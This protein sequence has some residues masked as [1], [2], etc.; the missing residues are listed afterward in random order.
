MMFAFLLLGVSCTDLD[1]F[2]ESQL[3]ADQ[4]FADPGNIELI[5]AKVYASLAVSG[6]SGPSGD[7]DLR[8][9]DEGRGQYL[10]VWWKLQELPTDEAVIAW[11]DG[12]IQDLNQQ[13]WTSEEDFTEFAYQQVF[14]FISNAN[15]F[16][17]AAADVSSADVPEIN[18]FIAEARF[19]RALGYWHGIDLFGNIPFATENDATGNVLPQ[20][21]SRAEIFEFIE[22]ELIE[23]ENELLPAGSA[24]YGRA[25]RGAAWMLQAKLYLNAEV[26]TGTDRYDDC[27]VAVNKIIN[28]GSYALSPSYTLN[29]LA[30]NHTSPEIIFPVPNDGENTQSFGNTTFLIH[31]AIGGTQNLEEFGVTAGWF[32]I[33]STGFFA[34]LFTDTNSD[35][36]L[37]R[38]E[39][40]DPDISK[41]VEVLSDFNDGYPVEKYRNVTSTGQPGSDGEH[42][43]AYLMYAEAV[44]Q[45]G[46]GGDMGIAT[47]LVNELRTRANTAQITQADLTLDFILDERARELYWE[48]HRRTD[49]V[50]FDQFTTNGIWEW[51]GGVQEGTTTPAFRN[52][53]PIP[54]SEL[55]ANP[56]LRQNDDY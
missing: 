44:L 30:D 37:F 45:G 24:P 42:V 25:D 55:I 56:T 35:R 22:S 12:T 38:T 23:I 39:I 13:T 21:R 33:R 52:I 40:D 4:V 48:G 6:Q 41:E 7:P 11:G 20:Q 27:L 18:T 29:F 19:L 36:Y 26:Y 2:P 5:L 28:S 17:R 49:L 9:F 54:A 32:G 15:A 10:R 51:K 50:R 43:D 34:D 14:I 31:A 8:G 3:T 53:Y 16:L 46:S 47:D 1:E